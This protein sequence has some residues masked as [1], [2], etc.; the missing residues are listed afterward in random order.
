M[1]SSVLAG[2]VSARK[3]NHFANHSELTR[4]DLLAKNL[5]RASRM[6]KKNG[7]VREMEAFERVSPKT[8]ALPGDLALFSRS[9]P[10]T[11]V[12]INSYVKF[13]SR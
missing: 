1:A 12:A 3:V 8:F 9:D 10:K 13:R 4:K 6:A 2:K 7:N 5:Q 11:D